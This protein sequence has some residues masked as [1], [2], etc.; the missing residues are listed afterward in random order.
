VFWVH[1]YGVG[2]H[3]LQFFQDPSC[4]ESLTTSSHPQDN[5]MPL[6]ELRDKVLTE[7]H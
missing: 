7:P 1:E 2:S 6:A 5:G 4:E 3:R